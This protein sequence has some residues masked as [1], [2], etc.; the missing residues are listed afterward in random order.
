M[1]LKRK[2]AASKSPLMGN[3]MQFLRELMKDYKDEIQEI[4]AE[5]RQLMAEIDFDLKRFEQQE[6][7]DA[8]ALQNV[9][10]RTD[11]SIPP[12]PPELVDQE[13]AVRPQSDRRSR[14]SQQVARSEVTNRTV[15]NADESNANDKM[16]EA[17]AYRSEEAV[18]SDT[19]NP[20][21]GATSSSS[22]ARDKTTTEQEHVLEDDKNPVPPTNELQNEMEVDEEPPVVQSSPPRLPE[23]NLPPPSRN[24]ST[25]L[26]RSR[27]MSTPNRNIPV[28]EVSFQIRDADI[29]DI[30]QADPEPKKR[31]R[32]I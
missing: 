26:L 31:K 32:R 17:N 23:P 27:I 21:D 16:T 29:S 4:L 3:L 2:L 15:V 19:N 20:V 6:R 12:V 10:P 11:R 7:E 9:A 13:E 24:L 22:T 25:R 28:D 5:D 18:Q 8:A 30:P 1:A 14:V